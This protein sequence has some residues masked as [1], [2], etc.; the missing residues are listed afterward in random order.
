MERSQVT[1]TSLEQRHAPRTKRGLRF[2]LAFSSPLEASS[3]PKPSDA[4]P[5]VHLLDKWLRL[6][7]WRDLATAIITQK[8][9]PRRV[10]I[11]LVNIADCAL[12]V[13][14]IDRHENCP[15][16]FFFSSSNEST[17]LKSSSNQNSARNRNSSPSILRKKKHLSPI[18]KEEENSVHSFFKPW[19]VMNL[20]RESADR[21][22][23]RGEDKKGE[24]N[25]PVV[26]SGGG[27][28]RRCP[29]KS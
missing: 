20:R 26:E 18:E 4:R 2:Y 12:D 25:K 28:D 15:C 17:R 5:L 7:R 11:S 19:S 10:L 13:K 3:N 8:P 23:E 9:M 14:M 16:Q 27:G 24:G 29:C 6:I 21:R 1:L 22:I